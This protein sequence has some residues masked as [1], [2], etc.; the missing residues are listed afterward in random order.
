MSSKV[1]NLSMRWGAY[2]LII[3]NIKVA[4]GNCFETYMNTVHSQSIIE[5]GSDIFT[6]HKKLHVWIWWKSD[7]NVTFVD[8]LA[9]LRF[10]T[11]CKCSECGHICT[12]V[13]LSGDLSF[14]I[15]FQSWGICNHLT[16][17]NG[18]FQP[19][20]AHTGNI[21]IV[22]VYFNK[23]WGNIYQ[24]VHYCTKHWFSL[25]QPTPEQSLVEK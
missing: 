15:K 22:I 13:N 19:W 3:G 10:I 7:A 8:I 6:L 1:G 21:T 12:V 23:L 2:S 16:I 4:F 5:D 17:D 9:S 11:M 20:P 18:I 25:L 24:Y 14:D